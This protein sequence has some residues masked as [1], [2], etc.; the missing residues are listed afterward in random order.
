MGLDIEE[1]IFSFGAAAYVVL[2]LAPFYFWRIKN[3]TRKDC[4]LTFGFIILMLLICIFTY[5]SR[6]MGINELP[7]SPSNSFFT[8]LIVIGVTTVVGLAVRL[9]RFDA[10]KDRP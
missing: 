6:L 3:I 5:S 8:V 2:T 7:L 4:F 9:F 1:K 10:L